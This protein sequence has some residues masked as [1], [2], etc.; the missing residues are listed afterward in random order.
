MESFPQQCRFSSESLENIR[1]YNCAQILT[2]CS[3]LL[4]VLSCSQIEDQI[5]RLA[6][7]LNLAA[8]V[9]LALV[10]ML[11]KGERYEN[12]CELTGCL[13]CRNAELTWTLSNY[14]MLSFDLSATNRQLLRV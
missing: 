2:Q 5:K 14:Q 12:M 6:G 9:S 7:D 10:K 11:E 13:V 8:V 1:P 4:N 3:A